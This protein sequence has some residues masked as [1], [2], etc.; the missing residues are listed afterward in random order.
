MISTFAMHVIPEY[1]EVIKDSSDVLK[2]GKNFV[3]LDIKLLSNLF[4]IF[5]PLLVL[6]VKPFG[7]SLKL[8]KH[9]PW[10]AIDK[11][12][13]NISFSEIYMGFAYIAKGQ[14]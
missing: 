10:E 8:F 7:V 2:S 12:F 11:N 3:L 9:R 6:L 1:E 14:R 4:L 13:H 5:T